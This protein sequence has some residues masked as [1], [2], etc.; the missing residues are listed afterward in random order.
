VNW[1]AQLQQAQPI[2]HGVLV[3]CLVAG[4]LVGHVGIAV[5]RVILGFVAS[6]G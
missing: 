3:L 6:S 5:D 1:V 4:I 2:A